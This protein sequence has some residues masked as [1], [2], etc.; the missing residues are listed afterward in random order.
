MKHIGC[1]I[2]LILVTT[3]SISVYS[4][5]KEHK[6]IYDFPIPQ[7]LEKC[8]GILDKTMNKNEK[9]LIKTLQEDSIYFHKEFQYGT[10]FFDAWKLYDGSVL[11]NYFNRIGI[12][13]SHEIYETILISYHRYLNQKEIK[14]N[15]Q[16]A[17]Y[18][19][20]QQ[21]ERIEVTKK[22]NNNQLDSLILSSLSLYIHKDKQYIEERTLK[23]YL[24]FSIDNYPPFFNFKD[25]IQ[26]IKLK[27][28]SITNYTGFEKR[29][30]KGI[31]VISL[32][33]TEL[34][35]NRLTIVFAPYAVK[36]M[37]K[38]H[39]NMIV[40]ESY[41]FIYEYSCDKQ[42]WILTDSTYNGI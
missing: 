5:T 29:L 21:K 24:Y 2:I 7:T 4:Q 12:F 41:S 13:N 38:R 20:I 23:D 6:T 22:A 11:T 14:I 10:D 32:T 3:I 26:G 30:K 19:T 9:D 1:L 33:K 36:L 18:K 37:N 15:E 16:I 28:I 8:F 35:N 42:K 27:Y 34:H 25:S 40:G 31:G 39:L 17:R